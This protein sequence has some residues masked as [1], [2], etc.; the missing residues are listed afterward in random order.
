MEFNYIYA[1]ENIYLHFELCI[2]KHLAILVNKM[3]IFPCKEHIYDLFSLK[4]YF[5]VFCAKFICVLKAFQ[6]LSMKCNVK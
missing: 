1:G 4:I 6:I 2:L 3:Y 5:C